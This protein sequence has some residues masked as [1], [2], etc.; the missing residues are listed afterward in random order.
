MIVLSEAQ[1]VVLSKLCNGE[2]PLV[3]PITRRWLQRRG[4]ITIRRIGKSPKLE[5][6]VTDLGR[7]VMTQAVKRVDQ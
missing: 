7:E 6:T 2:R 4:Y 3:P 1:W 5:I